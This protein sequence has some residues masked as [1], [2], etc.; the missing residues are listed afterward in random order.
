MNTLVQR[1]RAWAPATKAAALLLLPLPLC[2]AVLAALVAGDVSRLSL[3]GGALGCL[4]G[5]AALAFRALAAEARYFLGELPD[6]PPVPMKLI[7]AILTVIGAAL[8]ALA[9]GHQV[10]GT[11]AFAGLA[12]LGHFAFFGRDIKSPRIQVTVLEGVDATA[13]TQQLKQAHGRLRGIEAAALS[14]A[15]PEFRDRLKRITGIGRT[16][17]GEIERDP[18][19]AVRARRFLNLYLDSAERVT[20]DYARTHRQLRSQPL[21]Q[22]FRQLLVDME[23]T[24]AEQ[25]K[26]LVER[27]LVSLDVDI[28]V[29]NVRMKREGLG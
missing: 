9:G 17:L 12:G 15:V 11:V 1:G 20:L 2:V 21:E 5:A 4:W 6:P 10:P 7:S 25:H 19:E 23:G 13:V 16:I 22:N 28:E 8:A 18:R 14:I 29:L 3:A 24:F 26:K 27:D